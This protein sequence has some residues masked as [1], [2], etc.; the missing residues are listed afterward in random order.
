MIIHQG[1]LGDLLLSLPALISLRRHHS[2]SRLALAGNPSNLS[3]LQHRLQVRDLHSTMGKDW[4]GLYQGTPRLSEGLSAFL[5]KIQ[6]VYVFAPRPPDLLAENIKEAGSAEVV[7]IPSFPDKAAGKSIPLVQQVALN[8]LNISW[9]SPKVYLVSSRGERSAGEALLKSLGLEVSKGIPIWA[10]HPGSGGLQKNWPIE[11]F[12]TLAEKLRQEQAAV[13]FFILGPVER[14]VR[15]EIR[16]LIGGQGF[17]ILEETSLALLAG[18]LSWSDGYLGNDSGVTHLA[19][20]LNLP[21]LALF[22][23]TDPH[24]WGPIGRKTVVR[25]S[26]GTWPSLTVEAVLRECLRMLA[27]TK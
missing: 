1:A 18:V 24:L 5:K 8:A 9:I 4:A 11:N 10:I 20:C 27:A 6:R 13:P 7:W 16:A 3:L 23:P 22:G 12:L 14:E 15:P 2:G 25:R 21:T 26:D 19:S 17:P